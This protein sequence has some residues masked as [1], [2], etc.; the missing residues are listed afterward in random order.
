[1]EILAIEGD[2]LGRGEGLDP[3]QPAGD[4]APE[5]LRIGLDPLARGLIGGGVHMSLLGPL[6]GHWKH[7]AFAHVTLPQGFAAKYPEWEAQRKNAVTRGR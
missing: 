5:A 7:L 1:V 2:V 4:L 3:V 6:G